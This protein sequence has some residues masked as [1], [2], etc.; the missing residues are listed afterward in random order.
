MHQP[1]TKRCPPQSQHSE[2]AGCRAQ[3]P[4]KHKHYGASKS[5]KRPK[6]SRN[7]GTN[8]YN[9]FLLNNPLDF[10]IAPPS[11]FSFASAPF[12]CSTNLWGHLSDV[13]CYLLPHVCLIFFLPSVLFDGLF[14]EDLCLLLFQFSPLRS[15]DLG[16][17]TIGAQLKMKYHHHKFMLRDNTLPRFHLT[18]QVCKCMFRGGSRRFWVWYKDL[19]WKASY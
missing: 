12:S 10:F 6:W 16:F 9:I 18:I 14:L 5:P 3:P 1:N 17:I 11:I 4:Q 19:L 2:L 8:V 15:Y 13:G 7:H